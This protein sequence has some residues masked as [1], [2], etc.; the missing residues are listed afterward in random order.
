[1][2]RL[3]IV[4]QIRVRQWTNLLHKRNDLDGFPDISIVNILAVDW[5]NSYGEHV[6]NV[7]QPVLV[8]QRPITNSNFLWSGIKR[9]V[10][11]QNGGTRFPIDT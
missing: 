10:L 4:Q 11:H 3:T 7:S 2:A 1:M 5:N 6:T 9:Q 8:K